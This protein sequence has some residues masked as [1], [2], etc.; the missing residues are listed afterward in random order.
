MKSSYH[1]YDLLS[2]LI[3]GQKIEQHSCHSK[4]DESYCYQTF[5][6]QQSAKRR[7]SNSQEELGKKF[8]DEEINQQATFQCLSMK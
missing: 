3:C 6:E 7:Q 4:L 2:F 5:T 8:Y 1:L